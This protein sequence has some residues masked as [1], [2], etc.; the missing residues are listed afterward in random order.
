LGGLNVRIKAGTKKNTGLRGTKPAVPN[1]QEPS[2]RPDEPAA[3]E[4]GEKKRVGR[5]RK[6]IHGRV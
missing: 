6:N 5:R 2:K 1:T 3:H 4:L